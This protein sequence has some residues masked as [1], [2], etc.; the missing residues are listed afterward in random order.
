M[1]TF[2]QQIMKTKKRLMP[3]SLLIAGGSIVIAPLTACHKN[4]DNTNNTSDEKK[5]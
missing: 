5:R 1:K 3:L 2:M 4:D